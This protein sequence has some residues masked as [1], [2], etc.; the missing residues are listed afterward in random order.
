MKLL[1]RRYVIS[2]LKKKLILIL[3]IQFKK[4]DHNAKSNEIENKITIDHD[5]SNKY[6][7]S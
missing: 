7:T 1:K 5:H 2:Y 4:A 3:L 6:V